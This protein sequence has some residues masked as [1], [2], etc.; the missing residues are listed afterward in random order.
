MDDFDLRDLLSPP[1]RYQ[2]EWRQ[3]DPIHHNPPA[4]P[5]PEPIVLAM[6]YVPAQ[7]WQELYEPQEGFPR[8]TIFRQLNLPFEGGA[9]R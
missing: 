3:K 6:G 8:G 9:H 5:H 4:D 2:A 7:V 1:L